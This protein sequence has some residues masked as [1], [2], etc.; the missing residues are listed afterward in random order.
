METNA[1][2]SWRDFTAPFHD[3]NICCSA[4]AARD[5]HDAVDTERNPD[6][7]SN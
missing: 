6:A 1:N 7:W 4:P 2:G 3:L 5:I